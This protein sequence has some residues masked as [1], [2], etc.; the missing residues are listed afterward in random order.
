MFFYALKGRGRNMIQ[1]KLSIS[2]LILIFV[3]SFMLFWSVSCASETN[4]PKEIVK[5]AKDW[6]VANKDYSNSRASIDS[7]INSG[8]VSELG[9]AW[10]F[11][12]P[13]ASEWGAAATNPLI[14]GNTVYLQDLKSSI[15]AID[16]KNGELIWNKEY[17][18][19][20]AGPTGPAIADGKIFITKGHYEAAALDMKGNELWSV[21]LSDTKMSA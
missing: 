7:K 20:N 10:A 19:D 14:L 13:G 1:K 4:V 15:Y 16:F 6:P 8:N 2:L 9:I 3:I 5:Y 21:K 11:A 12:I 18:L 17:S